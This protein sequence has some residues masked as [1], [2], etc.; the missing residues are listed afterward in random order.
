VIVMSRKRQ[1]G[2][3][4]LR[5][6][7]LRG[8]AGALLCASAIGGAQ[9]AT[10]AS[11]DFVTRAAQAGMAEVKLS[12]L[13]KSQGENP[14]VRGYA[15]NMIADHGKAGAELEAIADQKKLKLP[16]ELD[17]A[18]QAAMKNLAAKSG[19]DF[20]TAYMMLMRQDHDKAVSLFRSAA[21][22]PA[23]DADLKAFAAKTLPTLETHDEMARKLPMGPNGMMMKKAAPAGGAPH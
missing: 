22:S 1:I 20:D 16:A 18:H 17:A 19:P 21:D 8:S 4:A 3:S 6:L 7:F 2:L 14:A 10:S 13:A 15:D 9:N 23:L 5:A 11:Q 12:Q